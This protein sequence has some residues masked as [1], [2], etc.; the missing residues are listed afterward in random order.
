MTNRLIKC[1]LFFSFVT[2]VS[3]TAHAQLLHDDFNGT[4]IDTNLWQTSEPFSG[5]SITESGG[6][7][8]FDNRG[9]LITLAN[10]P[11][12]NS[13]SGAFAI[14]GANSDEFKVVIRTDGTFVNDQF[15]ES[16]N[17]FIVRFRS[18]SFFASDEVSIQEIGGTAFSGWTGTLNLNT[19]YQFKIVDD[20]NNIYVFL[21]NMSAPKVVLTS[22]DS[23]GNK[24]VFYNREQINSIMHETKLDYV[25]TNYTWSTTTTGFA[26]LNAA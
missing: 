6:N 10:H 13:I 12:P 26:W 17:G 18:N 9:R 21:G 7:A 25:Q 3:V 15:G 1:A 8:I 5:S 19:K 20:G 4:S 22:S 11:G 23:F 2:M 24:L 16:A 14:T